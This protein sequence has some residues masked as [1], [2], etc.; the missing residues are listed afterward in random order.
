MK[1]EMK[2]THSRVGDVCLIRQFDDHSGQRVFV[3]HG[4]VGP[5]PVVFQTEK[6]RRRARAK[7]ARDRLRRK[8]HT[9]IYN[10]K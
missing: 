3:A 9:K 7:A 2:Y 1:L 6:P 10:N 8:K 5:R 4:V